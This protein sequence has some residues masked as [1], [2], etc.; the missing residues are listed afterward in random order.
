MLVTVVGFVIVLGFLVLVHELGHFLVARAFGIAVEE[1]GLGFPPKLFRKKVGETVYSVNAVPLGGFVKIKGEDG[2]R[3]DAPKD[4]FSAQ[5]VAA[6]AAVIVAGVSSNVVAGWL[7]LVVLFALGAPV[8]RGAGIEEKYIRNVRLSVVEVLGGSPAAKAGIMVGDTIVGVD[9]QPFVDI[10]AFQEYVAADEDRALLV[11]YARV[12][13]E[14]SAEVEPRE[15]AGAGTD[16]AVI[17]VGL[18]EVGVVRLPPHLAVVAGTRATG[19]Y[20]ERIASAFWSILRSVGAGRGVGESLGGPVA[21]A[22]ATGDALS[23]GI[24]QLVIFTAILSFNLAIINILPFP[25]LDGGRLIF[26]AAEAIRKKPSRAAVEAWFHRVGFAL[27]ILL[28]A[29]ITYRDIG[30]FGGRIWQAV[31]G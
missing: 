17:G 22:V 5:P 8:E 19:A 30:R 18:S 15:L 9:G 28:A 3:A 29:V 16:R 13:R 27:L 2:E 1:F 7:L 21:I 11:R 6:R 4:S 14:Y 31:L 24:A 12:G 20:L 10:Q 25:A 26:L 23:V